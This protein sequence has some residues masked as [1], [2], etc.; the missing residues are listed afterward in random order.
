MVYV[1]SVS[2]VIFEIHTNFKILWFKEQILG[3]KLKTCGKAY[4]K[5]GQKIIDVSSIMNIWKFI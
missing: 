5:A 3:D 1:I 2:I 4:V